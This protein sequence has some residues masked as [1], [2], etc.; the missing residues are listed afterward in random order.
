MGRPSATK[1][2]NVA[3]RLDGL[4]GGVSSIVGPTSA[5]A[6]GRGVVVQLG[7]AVAVNLNAAASTTI[8]TTPAAG[9][10]RCVVLRVIR[11]NE[12][13][14]ATT[15]SVQFGTA[16]GADWAATAVNA[17]AVAGKYQEIPSVATLSP[18][19]GVSTTFQ[20]TVTIV[21]GA[22]ATADL[23]AWGYYE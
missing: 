20:A 16:G 10:T 12:S 23:T 14:A 13:I 8:F 18:V 9:F 2:D 4:A 17:N 3:V 6:G 7:K 22:A 21:Q 19:Y 1:L 15:A 5:P 11:D